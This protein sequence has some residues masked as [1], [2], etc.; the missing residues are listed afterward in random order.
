MPDGALMQQLGWRVAG[1]AVVL[2]GWLCAGR[3]ASSEELTA[4]ASRRLL[5]EATPTI[6]AVEPVPPSQR[7]LGATLEMTAF[8]FQR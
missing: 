2:A 3:P 5:A 1:V 6:A 8:Q 4:D 7:P